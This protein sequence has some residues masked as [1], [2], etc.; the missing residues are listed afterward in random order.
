MPLD[1]PVTIATLLDSLLIFTIVLLTPRTPNVSRCEL[2]LARMKISIYAPY[3]KERFETARQ[4]SILH[5]E[6]IVANPS[7][8]GLWKDCPLIRPKPAVTARIA[9]YIVRTARNR[10]L[11]SATR[12]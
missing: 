11:P 6:R 8:I 3:A 2:R 5:P 7:L 10:A 4:H 1:A 9:D 12:S